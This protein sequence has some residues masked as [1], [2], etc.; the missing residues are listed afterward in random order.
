MV[1][2]VV[3]DGVEGVDA[4]GADAVGVVVAAA[5]AAVVESVMGMLL[6]VLKSRGVWGLLDLSLGD[7]AGSGLDGRFAGGLQLDHQRA[8]FVIGLA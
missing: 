8:D 6:G 4:M 1:G 2:A 5:G 3:V 7:M